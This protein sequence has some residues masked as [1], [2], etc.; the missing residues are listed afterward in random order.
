MSSYSSAVFSPTVNVGDLQD[1]QYVILSSSDCKK[2][3]KH[4]E[5]IDIKRL[6]KSVGKAQMS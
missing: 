1:D 5:I 6:A 2:L 4:L 3:R